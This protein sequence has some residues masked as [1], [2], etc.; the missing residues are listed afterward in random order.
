MERVMAAMSSKEPD[1]NPVFAVLGVYG[2]KLLDIPL[3][4]LYQD[5]EAWVAGQKAVVD[6]FGIDIVLGFFDHSR[7][8]EA[9]GGTVVFFENQAPNMKKPGFEDVEHFLDTPLPDSRASGRLGLSLE[10]LKKCREHFG[11]TVPVAAVVPGLTAIPVLIFG[12]EL[13]MET[14][15]FESEKAAQ[16]LEKLKPFWKDWLAAIF[17]NGAHFTITTEGM[18]EKSITTRDLYLNELHPFTEFAYECSPG[19]LIFHHTGGCINHIMDLIARLPNLGAVAI[20]SKD[21]IEEARQLLGPGTT[22]IGNMDNLAFPN[23]Q[24]GLMKERTNKLCATAHA[25]KPFILCTSGADLHVE[26]S[27]DV[28]Q[29]YIKTGKSYG[30]N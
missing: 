11:D 2:G 13:W 3:A 8:A 6:T 24:I 27:V 20:G 28:I 19:P 9:F 14:I 4:T 30:R 5:S 25:N 10:C 17:E 22:L 1:M 12:M 21:S 15:L 23:S 7:V 29:C 18:A 26:S 16:V